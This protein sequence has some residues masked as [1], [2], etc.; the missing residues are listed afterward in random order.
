MSIITYKPL[1]ILDPGFIKLQ[2]DIKWEPV[3][4]HKFVDKYHHWIDS[5]KHFSILGL[6]KFKYRSITDGVTGAF[7]NFDCMYPDKKT[8]VLKA[9][10]PFHRD[11][12][13]KVVNHYSELDSNDKFIISY[14]YAAS[15]DVPE[16]FDDIIDYCDLNDIP[17]FL[18]LAYFGLSKMPTLSTNR[19]CIKMVAFSMS[20]AFATGKCK[21]GLCYSVDSETT[22]MRL[23][24][25][26]SYVNHISA[27]LHSRIMDMYSPDYIYETYKSKQEFIAE[28]LGIDAS[29]TVILCT[30]FDK[31][32]NGFNRNGTINRL[33]VSDLLTRDLTTEIVLNAEWIEKP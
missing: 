27:S 2:S 18:D 31:K 26:Y 1:P 19:K 10:Y 17:V 12:G 11:T 30:T 33:G 9:E 22:P 6:D 8:T 13:A 29:P 32:F 25:Q 21:I 4:L 7:Y 15:G 20:K 23:L 5:S 24:N 16:D 3:D 14:P 28:S